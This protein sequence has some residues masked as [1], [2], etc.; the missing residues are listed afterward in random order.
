M[1]IVVHYILAGLVW[2]YLWS[3]VGW[4]LSLVAATVADK[5][6]GKPGKHGKTCE[7]EGEPLL[8]QALD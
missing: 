6:P 3:G 2:G 7:Y 5:R 8:G 1:D 4:V